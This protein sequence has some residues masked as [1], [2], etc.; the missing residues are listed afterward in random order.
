MWLGSGRASTLGLWITLS[1]KGVAWRGCCKDP[2]LTR[3]SLRNLS[4][5]SPHKELHK[6]DYNLNRHTALWSTKLTSHTWFHVLLSGGSPGFPFPS[7]LTGPSFHDCWSLSFLSLGLLPLFPM[8]FA[9]RGQ[10]KSSPLEKRRYRKPWGKPQIHWCPTSS[11]N[12]HDTT[13]YISEC[14]ELSHHRGAVQLSWPACGLC[15]L[16]FHLG[17]R[18]F[19]RQTFAKEMWYPQSCMAHQWQNKWISTLLFSFFL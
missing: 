9:V 7:W 15:P 10:R 3:R 14:A 18:G 6:K 13:H 12:S 4:G 5:G 16:K 1:L 17:N 11:R 2:P 19:G 8:L